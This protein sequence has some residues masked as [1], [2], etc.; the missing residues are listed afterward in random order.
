MQVFADD[1]VHHGER[2]RGIAAR[3]DEEVLVRGGSGAVAV[4]I[5][6]VELRAVAP[7]FDDERPEM[8]V[9]AEDVRAPGDDQL[10]VAE[11]L[12]LGAVADAERLGHAGHAGGGADGAV[13]PRCA[14]AMEEA[15]IHA[16]GLSSPMVPA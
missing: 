3:V 13:E 14:Q 16:V 8:D 7:R 1:D 15:A 9:R 6:D 11:L 12:G 2:Q 4:R 10:R 5:D